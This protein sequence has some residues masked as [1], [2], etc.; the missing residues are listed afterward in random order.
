MPRG[1]DALIWKRSTQP[2]STHAVSARP[3]RLP[4]TERPQKWGLSFPCATSEVTDGPAWASHLMK[5]LEFHAQA[6]SI[7]R[8][9]HTPDGPGAWL[10]RARALAGFFSQFAGVASGRCLTRRGAHKSARESRFSRSDDVTTTHFREAADGTK[11]QVMEAGS[12]GRP[13][14]RQDP[15]QPLQPGG[16]PEAGAALA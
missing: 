8:R 7:L 3:A 16:R 4:A 2:M 6:A 11:W 12:G 14:R 1:R 10:S 9:P 5:T 13:P 15:E